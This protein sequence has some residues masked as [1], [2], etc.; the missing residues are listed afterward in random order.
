MSKEKSFSIFCSNCLFSPPVSTV[1]KQTKPKEKLAFTFHILDEHLGRSEYIFSYLLT[2]GAPCMRMSLKSQKLNE[3]NTLTKSS[4]KIL[5]FVLSSFRATESV[6]VQFVVE[7]LYSFCLWWWLTYRETR[8]WG[9]CRT[10][11]KWRSSHT[12][13]QSSLDDSRQKL[14]WK[15]DV[16]LLCLFSSLSVHTQ[17]HKSHWVSLSLNKSQ[18]VPSQTESLPSALQ[19][20]QQDASAWSLRL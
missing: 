4:A 20:H 1:E 11:Y 12:G 6:C 3:R 5:Q 18:R 15:R 17:I 16:C 19:S 13:A 14:N 8:P 2:W 9:Q 7:C 10:F